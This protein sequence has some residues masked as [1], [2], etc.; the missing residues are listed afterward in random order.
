MRQHGQGDV[1]VPA[2]PGADLVLV[3]PDLALGGLEAGLDRPA[4]PGHPHQRG[5]V[6]ALGRQRQVEGQ[7]VRLVELAPD[8]QALRPAGRGAAAVGQEGPVVEPRPLGALAGAQPLP[9]LGRAPRRPTRPRAGRPAAGRWSPPARSRARRAPR[10]AAAGRGRRRRRCP[11]SPRRTARRRP[12]PAP[13]SA[14]PSLGLVAKV[15]P[16]GTPAPARRP[17]SSAQPSG[18]YSARS[19]SARPCRLA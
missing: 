16:A 8:Q 19:I 9:A 13:A 14:A 2:G 1:P 6:R 4:R 3:Q 18:R 17:A 12:A 10:S 5:E 15:T 7:L 11:P